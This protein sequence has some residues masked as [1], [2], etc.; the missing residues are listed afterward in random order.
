M[1]KKH[2]VNGADGASALE[3]LLLQI[4]RVPMFNLVYG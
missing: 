4:G 1:A 2:A 3:T